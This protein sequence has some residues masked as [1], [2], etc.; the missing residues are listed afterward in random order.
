MKT[1]LLNITGMSCAGCATKIEEGLRKMPGVTEAS[2]NFL[3]GRA[4]VSFESA[5]TNRVDIE[6]R[7]LELGYKVAPEQAS[8]NRAARLRQ[9]TFAV[10]VGVLLFGGWLL[11]GHHVQH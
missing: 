8:A 4:S 9:I 5:E 6:K 3:T 2:V 11:G 1:E 10:A 7:V